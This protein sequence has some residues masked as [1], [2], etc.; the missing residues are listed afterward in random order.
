MAPSVSRRRP[1]GTRRG[2]RTVT[3]LGASLLALGVLAAAPV[4]ADGTHGQQLS[5]FD[6]RGTGTG[7]VNLTLTAAAVGFSAQ[8]NVN[9]H[10]ASPNTTFYVQRAPEFNTPYPIDGICQRAA[11]GSSGFVTL[12]RPLAGD[13]TTITTNGAGSGTAHLAIEL[14]FIPDGARF[15][16]EFRVVDSLGPAPANDLRTECFTVTVK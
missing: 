11:L 1:H 12:P 5:V 4:Q 2:A 6:G 7:I 16:V 10:G 14:P 15:D 9:I 3:L 8:V 13:F